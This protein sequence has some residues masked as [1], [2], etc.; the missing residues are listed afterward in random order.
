MV[1][2][3]SPAGQSLGVPM[4]TAEIL[5]A[6]GPE[7]DIPIQ[8]LLPDPVFVAVGKPKQFL[9]SPISA[10][11]E[12]LVA[13]TIVRGL[14][15]Y[16]IDPNSIERFVQ[17][18]GFPMPVVVNIP[19]PQ[20]PAAMPLQRVIPIPRRAMIITFS[21]AVDKSLLLASLLGFDPE[22]AFLESLKRTEGRNEYYD[23]TPPN[24]GIPQRLALGMIDE[25][26]AVMVEGVENDIKAVFSDTI[27]KNAILDRIKRT[28]VDVN[29][30][31]ILTSLEGLNMSPEALENMLEQINEVGFIPSSFVQAIKQ[32][33]RALTLSINV[34]VAIGQPV[35]SVY[36]EGRDEEGAEAIGDAIRGVVIFGQTTL[37]T[38]NENAK[39]MLPIPPDFAVSLLNAISIDVKGTQVNV[40]LNNFETLIPTINEQISEH[41]TAIEQ[42]MLEQRRMEQLQMLAE[43]CTAY[44]TQNGKFPA[45]ILDAEGKPLLSWRVALLPL[46]GPEGENF[47]SEFKLDEPWDSEANSKLMEMMPIIFHPFASDI[48]L[49]KTVIRFFD[50]P[51]TPFANRDLTLEDLKFPQTTLMLVVVSPEYAVEWTKPEPLEFDIEKIA[52]IVGDMLLGVVFE[53]QTWRVPVL[54]ESDPLHEKRKQDIEALVRG[55]PLDSQKPEEA[56]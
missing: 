11:G 31:T 28:P 12:W 1:T 17:S 46:M 40:V 56:Q 49:P 54:P 7:N 52:D 3:F 27:P 51:G 36:A 29:D 44:Y 22:P 16:D 42:E 24:L 14:Q 43:L 10:G 32:H 18:M 5:A 9:D 37:A 53:R 25:R 50:S 41:Q 38:M 13:N 30:L 45:D 33:L 21:T 23:L 19:N 47:Y 26:T 35:I 15:L 6:L 8:R 2:G 55:T 48:A 39:Q 20:N 34:S 4:P